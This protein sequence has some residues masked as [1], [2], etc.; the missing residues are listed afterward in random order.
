MPEVDDIEKLR[1]TRN[2]VD[3]E[4]PYHFL[5]EEEPGEN[6]NVQKV[7]T[8]FLTGKECAFKCLMCDLWKNTL[9]Y[10]TPPGTILK[11][12]DYAL[13]RLPDA[14]V[15]KLYNSSNFF[16]T[17]SIP[18]SDYPGIVERVRHFKKVDLKE[19]RHAS[20]FCFFSKNRSL[21]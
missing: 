15:I 12:I 21:L 19:Q 6:G 9:T 20:G 14:D 3:P 17:K 7:N 5:Q 18:L 13:S 8:I 2:A 1:P 4:I 10:P 16:D 11:Q